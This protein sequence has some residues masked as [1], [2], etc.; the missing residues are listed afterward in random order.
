MTKLA[1][2]PSNAAAVEIDGDALTA[3]L[4]SRVCHDL[5]SPINALNNG[6]E[7]MHG[8]DQGSRDQALKIVSDSAR[9]AGARLQ[10]FRVAFGASGAQ[11]EAEHADV[12][13]ELL[14]AYLQGGRV[15]LDWQQSAEIVPRQCVQLLLNIALVAYEALPRGGALRIAVLE[16]EAASDPRIKLVAMG[17]GPSI[18]FEDRIRLLLAEGRADLSEGPLLSKEAPAL[19]AHRLARGLQ[20]EL[21]FGAEPN[22]V[23]VA[24]TV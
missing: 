17:E 16:S 20:A 22:R 13:R 24:A 14:E 6:L 9:Q 23:L 11:G 12:L 21:S 1:A 3:L 2:S 18:K 15:T 7:F 4:T 10:F 8:A 19:L 5:A